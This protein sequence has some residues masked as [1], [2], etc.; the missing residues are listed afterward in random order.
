MSET[1]PPPQCPLRQSDSCGPQ[2]RPP[3]SQTQVK[4]DRWHLSQWWGRERWIPTCR[5]GDSWRRLRTKKDDVDCVQL[6]I[7]AVSPQASVWYYLLCDSITKY[8]RCLLSILQANWGIIIG[9]TL[10][11]IV[12]Q[13]SGCKS[14]FCILYVPTWGGTYWSVDP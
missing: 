12:I 8:F 9:H 3:W 11:S 14:P 1:P 13:L 5:A 4:A 10:N 7:A 2:L 6:T